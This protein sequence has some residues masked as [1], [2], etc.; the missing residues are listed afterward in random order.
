MKEKDRPGKGTPRKDPL[1]NKKKYNS[2]KAASRAVVQYCLA[3][4]LP[5]PL[6]HQASA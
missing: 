6:E 4:G 2:P 3:H 5:I 1:K